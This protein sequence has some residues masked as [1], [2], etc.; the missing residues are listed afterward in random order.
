MSN[1]KW[2]YTVTQVQFQTPPLDLTKPK[3]LE[4]IESMKRMGEDGWEL[5]NMIQQNMIFTMFWKR[6]KKKPGE[7]WTS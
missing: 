3:S 2:D 7:S 4:A 5:V 1:E 6:E